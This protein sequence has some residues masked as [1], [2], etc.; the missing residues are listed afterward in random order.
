MGNMRDMPNVQDGAIGADRVG[1]NQLL[2]RLMR[3]VTVSR[4]Y[5]SGGGEIAARLAQR[6]GWHLVDHEVVVEVAR[7]LGISEDEAEAHDEHVDTL[8][9]RIISSLSIVQSSVLAPLP[10]RLTID[11]PA[12]NE[13]RR[14]VVEGAVSVGNAV[15]VGRGAQVLLADR[16]DVLHAPIIAPLEQRIAYAMS[17][18]GLS[19]VAARQRI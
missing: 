11:K 18:E 16:R 10:T 4:E 13:A 17:R 5:G 12:Y 9:S 6:L 19:H 1:G 8:V 14:R 3:A 15:I 7:A 2:V